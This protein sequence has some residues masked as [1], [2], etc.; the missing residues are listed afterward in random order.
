MIDPKIDSDDALADAMKDPFADDGSAAAAAT[1]DEAP[2][3]DPFGAGGGAADPFGAGGG[4]AD[5]FGGGEA[6]PFGGD[7]FGD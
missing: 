3:A 1:A 5:P 2:V 4:A 6:D 7:A